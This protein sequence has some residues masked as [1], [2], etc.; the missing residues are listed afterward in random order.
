MSILWIIIAIALL[1]FFIWQLMQPKQG[2]K[3]S[4]APSPTPPGALLSGEAQEEANMVATVSPEKA[5]P[6]ATPKNVL[7]L[8]SA[9]NRRLQAE[10]EAFLYK[11]KK[12]MA[13]QRLRDFKH[14]ELQAAKDYVEAIEDE[15]TLSKAR[16]RMSDEASSARRQAVIRLLAENQRVNAVK[17]VREETNWRLDQAEEYVDAMQGALNILQAEVNHF[18]YTHQKAAA[19]RRVSTVTGWDLSKSIDYVEHLQKNLS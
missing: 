14:W 17:L 18:L 19:I 2:A 15:Q 11:G 10:V 1:L 4:N 6:P 3:A 16:N 9:A 13:I 7:D 12:M 5:P 8:S